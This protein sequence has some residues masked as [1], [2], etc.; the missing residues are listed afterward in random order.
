MAIIMWIYDH[1]IFCLP[2]YSFGGRGLRAKHG[3]A[4]KEY[5]A[6]RNADDK[7]FQNHGSLPEVVAQADFKDLDANTAVHLSGG[8]KVECCDDT[9]IS[10]RM[11]ESSFHR[12][13]RLWEDLTG[14][15][16]EQP[17]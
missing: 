10:G 17:W 2:L 16:R 12:L 11:I 7:N 9:A 4:L 14:V 1:D 6:L 8:F 3:N 15:A 13:V 5:V